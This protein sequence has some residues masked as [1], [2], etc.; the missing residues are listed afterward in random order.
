L[1]V[2]TRAGTYGDCQRLAGVMPAR[3]SRA[4]AVQ[5]WHSELIAVEDGA[6]LAVVL[7]FWP[8]PDE[9]GVA[10][11]ELWTLS[12]RGIPPGLLKRLVKLAR[13]TFAARA[14]SGDVAVIAHVRSR[15]GRT[16]ARLAGMQPV[17][18][19]W[20]GYERFKWHDQGGFGTV[21]A[22]G[23][24]GRGRTGATAAAGGAGQPAECRQ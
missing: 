7:G 10:S 18:S 6:E 9:D 4:L 23:G 24:Q 15:A 17:A 19:N 2:I 21:R 12:R 8:M 14:Y 16:L 13:S 5:C 11:F 3:Y 20:P 22:E 1:Q